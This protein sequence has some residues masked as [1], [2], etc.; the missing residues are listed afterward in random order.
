[1]QKSDTTLAHYAKEECNN[2]NNLQFNKLHN[3]LKHFYSNNNNIYTL[4]MVSSCNTE[5]SDKNIYNVNYNLVNVLC[6]MTIII[7]YFIMKQK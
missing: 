2:H 1:M 4:I 7:Y 3:K 5:K 6:L